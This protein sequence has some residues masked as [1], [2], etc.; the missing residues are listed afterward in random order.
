[1]KKII[2]ITLLILSL[3]PTVCL[4]HTSISRP[5][6]E[7]SIPD[8]NKNGVMPVEI[9]GDVD[10]WGIRLS[11]ND[12]VDAV[13]VSGVWLVKYREDYVEFVSF[14]EGT[15]YVTLEGSGYSP[16]NIY[17]NGYKDGRKVFSIC[18][19]GIYQSGISGG[20]FIKKRRW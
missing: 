7:V 19:G 5:V 15:I 11:Y 13:K 16:L 1:M 10:Y 17:F 2:F 20:S 14:G 18:S 4:A 8:V 6:V 9:S 3:V 12:C